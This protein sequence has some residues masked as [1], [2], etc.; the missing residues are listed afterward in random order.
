[1]DSKFAGGREALAW[2][3]VSLEVR[4]LERVLVCRGVWL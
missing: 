3:T 1:M 4:E 2:R